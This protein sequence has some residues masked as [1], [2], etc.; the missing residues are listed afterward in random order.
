MKIDKVIVSSDSNE[1]Y[2]DF[3]Q[4]VSFLWKEKFKIQPVLYYFYKNEEEREKYISEEFGKVIKIKCVDDIPVALQAQW[5]RYFFPS[6]DLESVWL[7]SDIDMLPMSQFYF[8]NQLKEVDNDSYVHLNPCME[9]YGRIPAC[10][11][12]AKG[13][14]YKEY[15]SLPDTWEESLYKVYNFS[16]NNNL[17][18]WST[19]ENFSTNELKDKKINF[20]RRDGGQNGHRLDRSSWRYDEKLILNQYYYDCHSIRPYK[21]FKKEIDNIVEKIMNSSVKYN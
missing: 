2:L 9:T 15:L 3:W 13:K 18:L 5:S 17:D 7:L 10:Y 4:P 20:I 11:H 6:H 14:K 1:F 19:D 8:I 16:I 21:S 12:V